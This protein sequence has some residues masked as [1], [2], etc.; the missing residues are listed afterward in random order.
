M[1]K[2][3]FDF[4][5]TL[6]LTGTPGPVPNG[7]FYD[8]CHSENY[9]HFGWTM[10]DNPHIEL[11]SGMTAQALVEREMKRKGVTI[12]DP[13][14]QRECFGKWTTDFNALVFRYDKVLNHYDVLPRHDTPDS[15]VLG[16]DLGFDDS[17]ALAVIGFNEKEKAAYLV[18]EAVYEKQGITELADQIDKLISTY[19]PNRVVMD[20]GGLGKKIAEEMR[21]RYALPIYPAEKARKFEYIE[22]LNDALRTRRFFAKSDGRFAQDCMLVEWDRENITEKLKVSDKFHSDIC[23]A[24]LYAYRESLHWLYQP[25]APIIKIHSPEW[26]LQQEREMEEAAQESLRAVKDAMGQDLDWSWDK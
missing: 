18:H 14:I 2:R 9:K 8:A 26:L 4:A 25:E 13:I 16:I 6:A 3:L 10:F 19:G 7:Y 20:T 23:D 12:E 22:L 11:K 15:Y 5:G 21:K 24:V 1:S 17:D